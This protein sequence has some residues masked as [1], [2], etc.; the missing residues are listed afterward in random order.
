MKII[1]LQKDIKPSA[2]EVAMGYRQVSKAKLVKQVK[3]LT[4]D[5]LTKFLSGLN[6]AISENTLQEIMLFLD[7]PFHFLYH[8][9]KPLRTSY[10]L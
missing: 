3:S 5:D 6:K 1:S 7:F 8:E 4:K 2:L 10:N 9:F